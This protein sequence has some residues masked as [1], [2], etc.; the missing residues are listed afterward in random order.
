MVMMFRERQDPLPLNPET[1]E[2]FRYQMLYD[3]GRAAYAETFAGLCVALIDGYGRDAVAKRL[4][5]A[6]VAVADLEERINV[7]IAKMRILHAVATQVVRQA[8]INVDHSAEI[9]RLPS[10][11]WELINDTRT[12]QPDIVEWPH[13]VPLVV[14]THEYQPYGAKPTPTGDAIQWINP[15]TERS[16][17]TSLAELGEIVVHVRED[18]GV[19]LA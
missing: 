7:E 14:S 5:D 6:G 11:H 2:T 8:E 9:E 4:A 3:R 13:S 16:L 17:I 15:F 12:T 1:D 19:G 10:K 18:K